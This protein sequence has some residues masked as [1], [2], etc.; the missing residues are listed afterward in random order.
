VFIDDGGYRLGGCG[1][2]GGLGRRG[3]FSMMMGPTT[4]GGWLMVAGTG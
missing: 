1:G 2:R 4:A 3:R